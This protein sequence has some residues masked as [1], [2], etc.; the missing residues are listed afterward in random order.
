[1][2]RDK[3]K[4]MDICSIP[5]NIDE[6]YRAELHDIVDSI[7]ESCDDESCFDH[8]DAAIIPSRESVIEII[9]ILK[10]ILYPGYFGQQEVDRHNLSYHIGNEVITI[11][12]KL[13]RQISRSILHDCR[14][15]KE[16]CTECLE[17]GYREAVVFLKK[18]PRLRRML[19]LDVRAAFEGDPAVRN[20]DE[21]IFSY[22]GL[23]AITIYRVAHELHLQKIPLIPRI[24]TE[25]AHSITGIDI[26][27]GAKIGEHFFI[28]HG[29]GV[30]IGETSVIG[31]NVKIYQGVTLGSLK[32]PRT[33]DGKVIRGI[34]RHPTVEDDVVIYANATIL[35]GETVIGA[36]CIIGGN[37]WLTRSVPPDTK[38]MVKDPELIFKPA[39]KPTARF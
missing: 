7:V 33:K 6:K 12:E 19:A 3:E 31:N 13:S 5:I 30:V 20:Y 23:L 37:V 22:P 28:D 18:I 14:R 36:R 11:F 35:G 9:E 24:M 15:Y 2:D 16:M 1:M 29:T 34:K 10:D 32:I 17:R 4:N 25:Y 21:I 26:H 27:P 39:T 38:V 8:V